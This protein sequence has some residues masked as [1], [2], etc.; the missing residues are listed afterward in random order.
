MHTASLYY[1]AALLLVIG[2][3][4]NLLASWVGMRFGGVGGAM[5]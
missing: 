2:V 5:R 1:S 3:T 4:S